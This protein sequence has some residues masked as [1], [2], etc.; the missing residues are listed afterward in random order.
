M[1]DRRTVS[2]FMLLITGLFICVFS[3]F[4]ISNGTQLAEAAERQSSY[5]LKVAATRGT[6]YD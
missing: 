6:I 4:G 1:A 5:R 2:V 3:V